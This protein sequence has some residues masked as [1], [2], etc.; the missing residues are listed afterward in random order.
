MTHSVAQ[1]LRVDVEVYD[2][3]IRTFIGGY[4]ELLDQAV[5]V[6][7]QLGPLDRVIDLGAGTGALSER[8]LETVPRA[9]VELWDVDADMMAKAA[10][11]LARF[12]DRARFVLRSFFEPLPPADAVMASL[13][14]HHVRD[15]P[16]KGTLYRSIA[17]SLRPGGGFVN[18]DVT[19]PS[20][21]TAG[22][23]S[24]RRWADHLVG[25]G[26]DPAGA[27]R[28]F[29][30][31]SAEDRYFSLEEELELIRAAGLQGSC[32][33]RRDPATLTVGR[34]R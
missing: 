33:W 30:E 12:G 19:I 25:S 5:T 20:D 2:R 27:W 8:L 31:W 29:D 3:A 6:L 24:Y 28:H 4:D 23:A 9:R 11:R 7:E 15:L 16:S 18:A 21:P 10:D 22:R 26:I 14:L 13:S 1:H 34:K 32:P 17:A